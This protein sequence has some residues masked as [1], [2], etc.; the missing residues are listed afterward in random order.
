[1]IIK[2]SKHNCI[3]TTTGR[4][5]ECGYELAGILD[6]HKKNEYYGVSL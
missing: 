4:W 3:R 2:K 1:M 6:F 5:A